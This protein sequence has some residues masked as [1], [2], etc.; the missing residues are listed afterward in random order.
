MGIQTGGQ[1]PD[2]AERVR[3]EAERGAALS[4]LAAS[5]S[6][7]LKFHGLA[8]EDGRRRE[9]VEADRLAHALARSERMRAV[10][11]VAIERLFAAVA[12]NGCCVVLSDADG[13]ALDRWGQPGDDRQFAEWGLWTG[14]DWSETAEGTNGI[15]TCAVEGRPVIIHR[16][17][18][19]HSRN[20]ALSCVAAPVFDHLGEMAGVLDVSSCRADQSRAVAKLIAHAVADAARRIETENFRRAHPDCRILVGEEHG[21]GGAMLLAVDRDDLV[22]GATRKARRLLDL[23]TGPIATPRPVCDLL[24]GERNGDLEAAER[25]VIRQALA[26]ARGNASAAARDL[27]LGRATLYRRMARLGLDRAA[28]AS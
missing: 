14:M 1:P 11:A 16:D 15:G 10:A 9:R 18:H 5:W 27:G 28:L 4:S 24:D 20:T 26:R 8:P 25:A 22:I 23:G 13:L 3:Q 6:R 7:S 12:D 21:Q 2:H 17:E 19:F